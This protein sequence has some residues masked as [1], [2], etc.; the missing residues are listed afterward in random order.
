MRTL[1]IG[2]VL[3]AVGVCLAAAPAAAQEGEMEKAKAAAAAHGHEH[4]HA[5]MAAP[6]EGGLVQA[7]VRSFDDA[8]GKLVSLAEAVPQEKYGWRPGEGVRSA[9]EVFM[10]VAGGNYF[11]S[12]G[13]GVAMPEGL[14]PE[15]EKE[16]DKAKILAALKASNDHARAAIAGASD[17]G[18][19]VELFGQK[20]TKADVVAILVGHVHEHLGQAIAYARANGVVPPWSQ[21]AP[22]AA[23]G[24]GAEGGR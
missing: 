15:M 11:L 20:F 16:T 14:S 3:A 13:L 8:S 7:L 12:G 17:L 5:M 1:G 2:L 10:H 22:A 24:E 18:A 9:S 21:P 19:E 6:A 4:H 23:E